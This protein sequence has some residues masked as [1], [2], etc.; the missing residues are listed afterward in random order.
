MI[1][2]STHIPLGPRRKWTEV[3]GTATLPG[4]K[5]WRYIVRC[6]HDGSREQ[7]VRGARIARQ[8]LRR[9]LDELYTSIGQEMNDR[10]HAHL[11]ARVDEMQARMLQ[12]GPIF[13]PPD[14]PR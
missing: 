13:E 4:G 7:R 6:E 3:M 5:I 10:L 12:G 9:M 2:F 14:P 8:H 1:T 11:H